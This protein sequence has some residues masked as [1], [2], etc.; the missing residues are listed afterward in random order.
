MKVTYGREVDAIY[1][2]LSD[3]NPEGVIEMADGLT[4]M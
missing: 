2:G 4:L 3:L 1:I